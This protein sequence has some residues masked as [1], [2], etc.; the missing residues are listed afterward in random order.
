M[1]SCQGCFRV[2]AEPVTNCASPSCRTATTQQSWSMCPRTAPG[3]QVVDCAEGKVCVVLA[4]HLVMQRRTRRSGDSVVHQEDTCLRFILGHGLQDVLEKCSSRNLTDY[5]WTEE[6]ASP[7]KELC[8]FVGSCVQATAD[9]E[10]QGQG[11]L[12]NSASFIAAF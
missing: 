1:G 9:L 2:T 8:K 6:F 11:P 3:C 7:R 12:Q 4:T 5:C 10:R